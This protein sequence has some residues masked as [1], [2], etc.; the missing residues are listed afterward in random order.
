M[1][2]A[3]DAIVFNLEASGRMLDAVTADLT[4]AD[5]TYRITPQANCA[6][7]LMG[8]LILTERRALTNIGYNDLP[9]LPD[10]FE[11]RFSRE[12][13]APFSTDFGDAAILT[14]LFDKHRGLMI[15]AVKHISVEKLEAP[16][17]KPNARMK[18]TGEMLVFMGIHLMSHAGQISMIRRSLGRAPLF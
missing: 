18:T 8:H 11:A 5:W 16:L 17:P 15:E 2:T 10:G 3:I 14:P 4:G 13:N 12:N 9:P 7:W 6:A 1:K